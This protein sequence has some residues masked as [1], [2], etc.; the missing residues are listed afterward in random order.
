MVQGVTIVGRAFSQALKQEIRYSQEAA[1]RSG[2]GE[3]GRKSAQSDLL[4][5][6][7]LQVS[8]LYGIVID[9]AI[10]KKNLYVKS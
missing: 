6:M 4:H 7:S 1:K 2:G 10:S 3:Q 9:A 8:G 5:G